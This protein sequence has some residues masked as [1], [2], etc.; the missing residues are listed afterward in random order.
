MDVERLAWPGNGDIIGHYFFYKS[1]LSPNAME[2][3]K[4]FGA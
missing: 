2:V 3:K 4:H 1:L